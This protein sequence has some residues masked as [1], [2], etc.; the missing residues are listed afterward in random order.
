MTKHALPVTMAKI[1]PGAMIGDIRGK[2]GGTV[3]SRNRYAN[4]T[5]NKTIPVNPRSDKQTE[6]RAAFGG[7]ASYWRQLSPE[8]RQ[9]WQNLADQLAPTNIFGNT[10]LYTGFNVMMKCNQTLSQGIGIAPIATPDPVVP[11]F[12]TTRITVATDWDE[13]IVT[14][15]LIAYFDSIQED[16][17]TG[18]YLQVQQTAPVAPSRNAGS[19]QNL[20]RNTHVYA[21]GDTPAD[22]LLYPFYSPVFGA[23]TDAMDGMLIYSRARLV[24][25]T[26]G[27]Y[28]PW[29]Q[30]SD[31]IEVVGA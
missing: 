7:N 25:A 24:H 30:W 22:I 2:Q 31:P 13:D 16:V 26:T 20:F 6:A 29:A 9:A 19:V 15:R 8:E 4:Y 3:Y 17:P 10:F 11:T 23:I 14:M 21:P 1:L 12:P 28:Q 5:R 27:L 18:F